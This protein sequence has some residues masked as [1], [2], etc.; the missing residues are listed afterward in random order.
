MLDYYQTAK[1]AS[2]QVN[3]DGL[4]ELQ[5]ILK[6]KSKIL[7]LGCGEGTRLNTL[8]DGKPKDA[9]GIDVNKEAITIAKR[10]YPKYEFLAY[11]G[12]KLPFKNNTFDV[13]YSAYVLEHTSDPTMFLTEAVRVLKKKGTLVIIC[14]NFGAPNRRSPNSTEK[15]VVK[16]FNGLL[17]D[18]LNQD[19]IS[20]KKVRPKNFYNQIDDDTTVEPYSR[21]VISHI[22]QRGLQITKWSTLWNLE[23]TT[24]NPRKLIVSIFGKFNIFPFTYWGP[25]IFVIAR[26]S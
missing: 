4:R 6:N 17:N 24:A 8:L 21:G 22:S 10:Q 11:D 9:V 14:P 1:H 20:W 15:P 19:H 3:N 26:K 13:V 12:A 7:D 2:S 23:A 25:Q 18:F 16:L 5:K